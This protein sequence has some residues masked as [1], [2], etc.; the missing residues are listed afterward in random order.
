MPS[1]GTS[2]IEDAIAG[3]SFEVEG[4]TTVTEFKAGSIL[5][6][7]LGKAIDAGWTSASPA[8][9]TTMAASFAATFTNLVGSGLAAINAIASGI[10]QEVALWVASFNPLTG[11]HTYAP[12]AA[13]IKSKILAASPVSSS[14]VSA[15]A[16][17]VADAFTSSFDPLV[18]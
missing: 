9:P 4:T 1:P 8:N 13:A 18:G 11:L 10:D 7:Q 2:A 14:G 16:Q 12:T 3:T 17:A 6:V 5:V 15:L